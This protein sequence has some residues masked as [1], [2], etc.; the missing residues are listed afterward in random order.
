MA[1]RLHGHVVWITGATSGIGRATAIELARRG[2]RV[3]VSGRREGRLAEVV[4]EIAGRGG[5]ALAVRCDVCEP[6]QQQDAV[7]RVVRELGRLDVAIANA[8]FSVSG[9][10][11]QLTADDWRRQ[12]ETN[13]VAAAM[14]ARYS[15]PELKRTRGRLALVGSVAAFMTAPGFGAYHASKYAVRALGA[16]LSAE[17]HGS[18]VSCTTVHPGFVASEIN[19]VDNHGRLHAERADQRPARLMWTAERA[20]RTVVDAIGRR[21][22]EVVFTGHGKVGAWLGMHLPSLVHLVMSSERMRREGA[23]FRVD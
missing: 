10:V 1:D 14:T 6:E 15:L 20:A 7:A 11:E 4:D 2:A 22:R 19:Q 12:L 8:G 18:G 16:T 5:E 13:V 23:T 9:R 17:L 21:K 3:A